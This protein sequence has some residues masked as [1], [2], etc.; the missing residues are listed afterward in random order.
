MRVCVCSFNEYV[1]NNL[2]QYATNIKY[3][4]NI[5]TQLVKPYKNQT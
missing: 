4:K 3:C 1:C 2:K 5:S